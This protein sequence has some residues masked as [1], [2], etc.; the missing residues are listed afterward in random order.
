MF[1]IH[2]ATV[3]NSVTNILS[4]MLSV[5]HARGITGAHSLKLVLISLTVFWQ[6]LIAVLQCAPLFFHCNRIPDFLKSWVHSFLEQDYIFQ[7]SLW[8][9]VAMGLS[10]GQW[11]T[12]MHATSL[13]R[14]QALCLSS[15][16]A[17]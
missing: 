17:S 4:N 1:L 8:V 13:W 7:P 9:G 15:R 16:L 2:F 5:T 12:S 6:R 11:D 3:D 10:S 14:G